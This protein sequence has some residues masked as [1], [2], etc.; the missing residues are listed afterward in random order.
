MITVYTPLS[1]K[2]ARRIL[3]KNIVGASRATLI[4]KILTRRDFT[5]ILL[6]NI[7]D[8][9][10]C[11]PSF[12]STGLI[13]YVITTPSLISA[14]DFSEFGW[15]NPIKYISYDPDNPPKLIKNIQAAHQQTPNKYRAFMDFSHKKVTLV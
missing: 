1:E 8:T 6:D 4:D 2:E 12:H 11:D 7:A 10:Q 14:I 5:D 15:I 3:H 13:I 9:V